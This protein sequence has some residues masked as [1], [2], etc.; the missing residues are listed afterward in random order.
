MHTDREGK[1]NS[2]WHLCTLFLSLYQM[3]GGRGM[4][5]IV[6][7]HPQTSMKLKEI[8]SWNYSKCGSSLWIDKAMRQNREPGNTAV[9][10]S[11]ADT[12]K[13]RHYPT[14]GKGQTRTTWQWDNSLSVLSKTHL[15]IDHVV[16]WVASL[17]LSLL[18]RLFTISVIKPFMTY[19]PVSN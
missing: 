7:E 11:G 4:L 17:P 5:L 10:T 16:L 8:T 13:R 18:F 14:A 2:E 1:F 3:S 12:W 15:V 19:T 9:Y 6:T